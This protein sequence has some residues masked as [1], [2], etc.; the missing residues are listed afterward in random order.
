MGVES[1]KKENTA[2]QREMASTLG[3]R[4][5]MATKK[6]LDLCSVCQLPFGFIR[7]KVT[8]WE[9]GVRLNY[10]LSCGT[11]LEKTSGP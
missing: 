11:E 2:R 5:S 4:T 10:C 1:N 3:R 7:A 6:E 8:G 9:N